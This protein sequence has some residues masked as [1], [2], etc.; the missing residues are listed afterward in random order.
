MIESKASLMLAGPVIQKQE[1]DCV[2]SLLITL[3]AV[4]NSNALLLLGRTGKVSS[5]FSYLNPSTVMPSFIY[6]NLPCNTLSFQRLLELSTSV[7]ISHH[8][9]SC[10]SAIF[11]SQWQRSCFIFF[12]FLVQESLRQKS[13]VFLTKIWGLGVGD[14]DLF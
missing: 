1:A 5:L 13:L 3:Y 2:C 8:L 9:C 12:F 7:P 11:F 10:N 6:S 14:W 4:P